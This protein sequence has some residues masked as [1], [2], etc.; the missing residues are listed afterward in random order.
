VSITTIILY[1]GY[2]GGKWAR[3]QGN[4]G[5]QLSLDRGCRAIAAVTPRWTADLRVARP[6]PRVARF[7]RLRASSPPPPILPTQLASSCRELLRPLRTRQTAA[8]YRVSQALKSC[9]HRDNIAFRQSTIKCKPLR[10]APTVHLK[11]AVIPV[12]STPGLCMPRVLASV[13]SRSC[14]ASAARD[15]CSRVMALMT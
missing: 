4:P 2:F 13:A 8:A 9:S 5:M 12:P 14:D 3:D 6:A 7:P 11:P 15:G 1:L 10:S